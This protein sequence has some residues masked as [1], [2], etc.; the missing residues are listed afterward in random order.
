M[1]FILRNFLFEEEFC[2]ILH[3]FYPTLKSKRIIQRY[4]IKT[5]FIKTEFVKCFK[6]LKYICIFLNVTLWI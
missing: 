4:N 5:Y 6:F 1:R 3:H 2:H